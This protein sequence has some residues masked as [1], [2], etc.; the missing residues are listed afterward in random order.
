MGG[1]DSCEQTQQIHLLRWYRD[2]MPNFSTE[3][4]TKTSENSDKPGK[5][6]GNQPTRTL[7]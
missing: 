1:K 5:V 6:N 3:S 2:P 7:T 4:H